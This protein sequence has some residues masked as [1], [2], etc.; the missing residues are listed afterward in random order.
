MKGKKGEERKEKGGRARY[1]E[2]RRRENRSLMNLVVL[3]PWLS[4][5]AKY[6][7]KRIYCIFLLSF[8]S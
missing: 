3:L 2:E 1:G 7:R 4:E 5:I 8:T 6:E